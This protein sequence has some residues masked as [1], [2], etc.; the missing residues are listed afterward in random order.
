[1]PSV[2]ETQAAAVLTRIALIEQHKG[3]DWRQLPFDDVKR[4]LHHLFGETTK[5]TGTGI[6]VCEDNRGN[7]VVTFKGQVEL[8]RLIVDG[9]PFLLGL[10]DLATAMWD[11]IRRKNERAIQTLNQERDG[12]LGE[13]KPSTAHKLAVPHNPMSNSDL[14]H[15]AARSVLAIRCRR[16]W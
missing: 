10:E 5:G 6:F 14:A 2:E 1:M 8:C 11:G 16:M 9:R 7:L 15:S 3:K 12:A 13:L 4:F